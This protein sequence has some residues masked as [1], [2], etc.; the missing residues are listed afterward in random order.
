MQSVLNVDAI[1]SEFLSD[2]YN[3][4]NPLLSLNQIKVSSS[5]M[6]VNALQSTKFPAV[7]QIGHRKIHKVAVEKVHAVIQIHKVASVENSRRKDQVKKPTSPTSGSDQ[8]YT[9]D[10]LDGRRNPVGAKLPCCGTGS[11]VNVT[12]KDLEI[13][14]TTPT[15]NIKFK[16]LE[17]SGVS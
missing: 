11:A 9:P 1:S 5:S 3:L 14:S 15:Q 7:P 10:Q 8:N 13:L 2:S 12:Q 4:W 17:R 6:S 16:G